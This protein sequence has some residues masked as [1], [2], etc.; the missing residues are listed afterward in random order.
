MAID[1]NIALGVKTPQFDSPLQTVGQL[2]QI[3]NAGQEYALRQQQAQLAQQKAQQEMEE[4]RLAVQDEN[5]LNAALKDPALAP[6]IMGGDL[7]PLYGKARPAFIMKAQEGIDAHIKNAAA[8]DAETLKNNDA[9]VGLIIKGVDG[10]HQMIQNETSWPEVQSAFTNWMGNLKAQ[11]VFNGLPLS[12]DLPTTLTDE[13]QLD[14]IAAGVGGLAS[15]YQK[16]LDRKKEHET[17]NTSVQNRESAEAKAERDA[18]TFETEQPVKQ[19]VAGFQMEHGGLTPEQQKQADQATRRIQEENTHFLETKRHNLKEEDLAGARLKKEAEAEKLL[20]PAEA[21]T[22]GVPYGTT[23]EGAKGKM[24]TTA[25]Q[26]TV[27]GYASRIRNASDELDRLDVNAYERNAPNFLNTA[28]GQQ[29]DQ[30]QR[31]F[32][33]AV[34]RRE[35]GA[36]I[37]QSEFDS[38][39]KQ[40]IPSTGD[41]KEVLQQK[42]NNRELQFA[43]FKKASGNAYQDPAEVIKQANQR[44]GEVQPITLKDGRVLRPHDAAAAEQFRKDHPD[45]IK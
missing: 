15:V 45:L 31:D 35:S 26:N 36:V 23:R 18:Q 33:N 21:A 44:S 20:T 10:F 41:S 43:A 24:P 13:K 40:Y 25:A 17:I 19:L 38:A 11:G 2:M 7:S 30:A 27:A 9:K 29:F 4:K 1:P 12:Q 37:N 32:I 5:T 14:Q 8:L 28:K 3:K 16:A 6:K 22:L 39:Y 42:K 34:L